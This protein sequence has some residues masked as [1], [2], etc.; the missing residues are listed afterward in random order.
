MF[1]WPETF[2][3]SLNDIHLTT[4]DVLFPLKSRLSMSHN[5]NYGIL[6]FKFYPRNSNKYH[7]VCYRKN[8]ANQIKSIAHANKEYINAR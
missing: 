1:P 4:F 7:L 8:L 2:I 6:Y 5:E 3:V